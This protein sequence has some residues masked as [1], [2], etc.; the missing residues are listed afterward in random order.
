MSGLTSNANLTGYRY[1]NGATVGEQFP[2]IPI[3]SARARIWIKVAGV[4]KQ[5]ITWIKVAGVWKQ[6][7]PNIKVSGAWR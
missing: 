5:A 6:A 4:W 2:N 3:Q 7:T 1:G